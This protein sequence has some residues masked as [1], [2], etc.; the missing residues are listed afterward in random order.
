MLRCPLR[1]DVRNVIFVDA[2]K[3]IVNCMRIDQLL[4]CGGRALE[5]KVRM[6]R[7]VQISSLLLDIAQEVGGK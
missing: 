5:A 7:R 4:K 1:S 3:V 2:H 6:S